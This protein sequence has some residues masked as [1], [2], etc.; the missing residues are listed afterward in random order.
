MA[1]ASALQSELRQSRPFRNPAQESLLAMMRTGAL[2]RGRLAAGLHGSDISP[3][4]YNVLRILRGSEPQGLPTLDIAARLID[5][6]P[7]ITRL[8]DKLETKKFLRRER[9]DEDRRQV[10]CR[11]SPA[12]LSLLASL[13]EPV[14]RAEDAAMSNLSSAEQQRLIILLAKLRATPKP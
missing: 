2:L 12:G 5:P 11:I 14:N 13:D 10:W 8:I 7:A 4:Q 3:E 6:T 9:S 1:A